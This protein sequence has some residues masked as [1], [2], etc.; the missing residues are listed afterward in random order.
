MP[1]DM[2]LAC[3]GNALRMLEDLRL[4]AYAVDFLLTKEES[5]QLGK[6]IATIASMVQTHALMNQNVCVCV[7][8]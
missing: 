4:E 6:S 8:L 1:Q 2:R 5:N 7:T 3:G